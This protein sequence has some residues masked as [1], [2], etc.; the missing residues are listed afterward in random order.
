MTRGAIGGNTVGGP[1][2]RR[3]GEAVRAGDRIVDV[4]AA[5][6]PG[7][8]VGWI[9]IELEHG[10]ES[11]RLGRL[12]STYERGVR[13]RGLLDPLDPDV[14]AEEALRRCVPR[15]PRRGRGARLL[16]RGHRDR[17]GLADRARLV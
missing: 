10:D 17:L 8:W 4:I 14:D 12:G 1:D 11:H 6:D 16:L 7:P 5:D 13:V 2:E 3:N 9:A 15:V